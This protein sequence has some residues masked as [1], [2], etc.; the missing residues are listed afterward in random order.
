MKKN[1]AWFVEETQVTKDPIK[2]YKVAEQ[3]VKV[4]LNLPKILCVVFMDVC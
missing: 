3:Y 2:L 4:C 1:L